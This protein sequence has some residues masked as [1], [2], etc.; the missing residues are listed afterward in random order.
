M[1]NTIV[2]IIGS[3]VVVVGSIAFAVSKIQD[4][5][6]EMN[7]NINKTVLDNSNIVTN[8]IKTLSEN[9]D[10]IKVSNQTLIEESVSKIDQLINN[11]IERLND[12]I[13]E[14]HENLVKNNDKIK[15]S[16]SDEL[17]LMD[18][19]IT[20][21]VNEVKKDTQTFNTRSEQLNNSINEN[22]EN[23]V[24]N[25]DKIKLSIIDELKSLDSKITSNVNEVKK[26]TQTFSTTFE[27]Y[28]IDN[29]NQLENSFQNTVRLINNLRL[30]NLINVSNEIGK[31]KNGIVEDEYFLQEVGSCKIIKFTDKQSGE[32]T[33]VYYNE[34]G[35]K[36]HTQT[37]LKDKLKYE[38]KYT[39]G[40]LSHGVE[41]NEQGQVIF[42]YEY[43]EAGE[44]STKIEYEYDKSG[45]QTEKSK[46]KY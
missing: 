27:K 25:N 6:K 22:H 4:S 9:I 29:K 36:S 24:K 31:Y 23:I 32:I 33:E 19:K 8:D 35:E 39:N 43:D 11:K 2:T 26:D 44:V 7:E 3:S 15:L 38:M 13:S 45:K 12:S 18:N 10:K 30:D 17:K 28:Q 5:I 42:A 16:I 41:Y 14:N 40:I 34:D 20:S 37:F 1:D 46:I 21:S